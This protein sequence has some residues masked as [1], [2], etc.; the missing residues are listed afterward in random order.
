MTTKPP[1]RIIDLTH[2]LSPDIPSWDGSCWFSLQTKVDYKDCTPPNLFRGQRIEAMSGA[3]THMDAPAHCVPGAVTIEALE[4]KDL[5]TDCI[6]I[7]AEGD[8][9][10]E[11]LVMP[12][13]I[14]AFEQEHGKIPPN[15]FVI[16]HTGW[17]KY[18]NDPKK[19]RNDLRFPSIHPDTAKLLLERNVA[20][21]G[22]DTLSPDA[23]GKDFP[24]HRVILGAGKYIVENVANAEHVPPMGAK[25]MVMPIKIKEGTEAPI[26]LVAVVS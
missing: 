14:T 6:V 21:I 1:R 5:I 7:H 13:A 24:V 19:Y 9:D 3:G 8:V 20:G 4:L 2:A 10:A 15:A 25:I 26:R 12:E 18:W 23:G 17:S 22:I 16:F 11:Y